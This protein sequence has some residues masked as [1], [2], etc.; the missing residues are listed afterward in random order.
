M[1]MEEAD[2]HFRPKADKEGL[3]FTTQLGTIVSYSKDYTTFSELKI[4]EKTYA[5]VTFQGKQGIVD[6][7]GKAVHK[8]FDTK[9]KG[10]FSEVLYNQSNRPIVIYTQTNDD[11]WSIYNSDGTLICENLDKNPNYQ[12]QYFLIQ[13]D[14]KHGVR[15]FVKFNIPTF[16]TE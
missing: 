3:G 2:K 7:E 8:N 11:K 12:S 10:I 13:K 9:Y 5:I 15:E 6:E 1:E 16:N 14:G 4:N